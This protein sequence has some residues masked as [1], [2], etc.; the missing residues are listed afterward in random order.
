MRRTARWAVALTVGGLAVGAAGA[1][2]AGAALSAVTAPRTVGPMIPAPTRAG[3]TA[4]SA[5]P[6]ALSTNWS[7]YAA[8]GSSKFNSVQGD[9]IQPSIVCSG[10]PAQFMAAWVGLDGFNDKTVEQDGTF[11]TCGGKNHRTPL[12]VAWYEMYPAGSVVVFPVSAGDEI[13]PSV[14]YVS[15]A[16]TLTVTDVTSGQIQSVTSACKS[17]RR[18]SAEWIIERPEL[19]T[20]KGSC[21]LKRAARFRHGH[22][23]GGH[24][25]DRRRA[26]AGAHLVVHQHTDRHDPAR[27]CVG[28]AAGPD[29]PARDDGGHLLRRVGEGRV[30]AARLSGPSER[31]AA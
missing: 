26:D 24:G 11:A 20:K 28:G 17:C 12:Y 13:Q 14:T 9:F 15:G 6:V 3:I 29:E 10:A 25:R 23:D 30:E 19:C 27:R 7:G 5:K 16:F 1:G 18:A 22:A 2:S 8:T 31:P 4:Q 21:F